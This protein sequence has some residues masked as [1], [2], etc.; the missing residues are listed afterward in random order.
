MFQL[1]ARI[2]SMRCDQKHGHTL[3]L[4]RA[5]SEATIPGIKIIKNPLKI[6]K[7]QDLFTLG[8]FLL[9]RPARVVGSWESSR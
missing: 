5:G 3:R 7:I 8:Q 4:Q 2:P 1:F 9:F 6:A